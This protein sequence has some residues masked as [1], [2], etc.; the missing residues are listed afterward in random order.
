MDTPV[1][2]HGVST[3]PGIS[4]SMRLVSVHAVPGLFRNAHCI[5]VD[6]S[7]PASARASAPSNWKKCVVNAVRF[8][9]LRACSAFDVSGADM[10]VFPL[11]GRSRVR[12][13]GYLREKVRFCCIPA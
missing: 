5:I 1:G 3:D 4:T 10:G 9:A 7:S 12:P 13:L 11:N 8:P 2:Y 6:R